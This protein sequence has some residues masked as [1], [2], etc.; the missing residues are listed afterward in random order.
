MKNLKGSFNDS[1]ELSGVF[2]DV[3]AGQYDIGLSVWTYTA[4][5]ERFVDL[6]VVFTWD[7]RTA[8]LVHQPLDIDPG[9]FIRPFTEFS[10]ALIFA[11]FTIQFIFLF[12]FQFLEK[13]KVSKSIV[14]LT[15]WIF[16]IILYAYY[17]GA[18]TMFFTVESILP[19]EKIEDAMLAVPKW[20]VIVL[21]GMEEDLKEKAR[22]VKSLDFF[23]CM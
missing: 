14:E 3:A 2:G 5:R 18:L 10:W 13:R 16:F 12:M 23:D 4:N 19:F 21:E 7:Y 15:A 8:S 22:Q 11:L 20:K 6:N 1:Q 17:S 9:L